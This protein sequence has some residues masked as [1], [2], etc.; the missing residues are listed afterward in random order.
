MYCSPPT[1]G[2]ARPTPGADR[3]GVSHS[4]HRPSLSKGICALAQIDWSCQPIF[5]KTRKRL[6]KNIV[7][8][9]HLITYIFYCDRKRTCNS[10]ELEKF[11]RWGKEHA[12]QALETREV[13]LH[14]ITKNHCMPKPCS[15]CS[16]RRTQ[17]FFT[18]LKT[19]ARSVTAV[20]FVGF[21]ASSP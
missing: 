8:K 9:I 15:L 20:T 16:G 21:T 18:P 7:Y 2:T 6:G 4:K 19:D 11:K 13:H 5:F 12:K 14:S 1:P 10:A 3:G 17:R